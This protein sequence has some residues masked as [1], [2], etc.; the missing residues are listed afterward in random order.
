MRKPIRVLLTIFYGFSVFWFFLINQTFINLE[1]VLYFETENILERRLAEVIP[2]TL[3]F[4]VTSV[5]M[6]SC[7]LIFQKKSVI[8]RENYKR[9]R[10][11]TLLGC[12]VLAGLLLTYE[13]MSIIVH[14]RFNWLHTLEL[15]S[16]L[17]LYAVGTYLPKWIFSKRRNGN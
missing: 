5:L 13:L 2:D 14:F 1:R 15:L 4:F 9:F 7:M 6:S 11:N 12:C 17:V 3:I 10:R 16:C 8:T